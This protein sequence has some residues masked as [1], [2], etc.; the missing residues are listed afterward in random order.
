M[1]QPTKQ[2]IKQRKG[3]SPRRIGWMRRRTAGAAALVAAGAMAL[4]G[5]D[6]YDIPL[7]G[8]ADTGANPMHLH[9]EFRD[10]LDLVPQSTVKLDDVTVGKITSIKLK[11]YT[12]DV[13]I[14][15][16]S[17]LKIPS[18]ERAEIRQTS[19]LGEKFVSLEKPADPSPE[20]LRDGDV[21]PLA[22]TGRNPEVE[23]VLKALSALLNGGGVAQLKTIAHELNLA[24]GGREQDIRS[25]LDQIHYFMGQL[26]QNK[27]SVVAAI[28][29]VDRLARELHRQDGTIKKT[30]D[31]LPAAIRSVNT[32]RADLVR[33]LHGLD[34]LSGVG[35][36]VIK[37]SK[38][39]TIDSLQDLAPVLDAFARAGQALPESMQVFATYP[40]VDAAVGNSPTVARNLHMGD[41]VNLSVLLHLDLAHLTIP[42]PPDIGDLLGSLCKQ[43]PSQLGGF[44]GKLA[45]TLGGLT[46]GLLGGATGGGNGGGNGGG[47]NLGGTLGGLLN[48]G[49][50]KQQSG[51]GG[52]QSHKSG[53]GGLG[54]VLGGLGLGRAELGAPYL[55]RTDHLGYLYSRA[56][57]GIGRL[58]VQGVTSR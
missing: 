55:R 49:G 10:V 7:P 17:K 18:N 58:L 5:C 37:Q 6:I 35:V 8:G 52:G 28:D 45:D 38:A 21:I 9:V 23:E 40:F 4:S 1:M 41:W 51:S 39:A 11:G 12:A 34:R 14:E 15:L 44:C 16:P 2:P 56:G 29:N 48:Q 33:M 53:G 36:R 20:R 27:K 26:A 32:Q 42:G 50:K 19:L 3:H 22:R 54:G 31:D 57:D 43:A 13:T 24:A 47:G 46:G 25:V 30:L